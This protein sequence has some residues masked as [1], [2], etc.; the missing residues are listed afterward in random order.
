M[1]KDLPPAPPEVEET[2]VGCPGGAGQRR[3]SGSSACRRRH[4]E[5]R[6]APFIPPRVQRPARRAHPRTQAGLQQQRPGHPSRPS[7][8]SRPGRP[9]RPGGGPPAR[10]GSDRN[11]PPVRTFGPDAE[12]GGGRK[13]GQER[14]ALVGGSGSGA[15]QHHAYAPGDEGSGGRKGRRTDEPS[16]QAVQ[17]GRLAEEKEREK[18]LVR[19]N[20][21]VS[22][23]E[24]A[25]G[26]EGAGHPDRPV[27]VQGAGPD[28]DG[29]PAARLRSDRADRVRLWFPGGPGGR[30]R[31]RSGAG[32][33]RGESGRAG[34]ASAGRD[35][36]GSRGP[37]QDLAARLCPQG[38]HRGRRG[39]WHHPAHRRLSRRAAGRQADHLPRYAGPPGLHRHAGARRPGHRH[40]RARRGG[41]RPGHAAD[42]RGD[43]PRPQRRRADDRRHQ[44]DRSARP[45]TCRR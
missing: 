2:E 35:H 32:S 8:P 42:R 43:Q 27:R 40:R 24:L 34:L 14:Q 41:G 1:F 12:K 21:F 36:H 39:G 17:A 3:R 20:E 16:F 37:R 9:S 13:K 6:R 38:Q 4:A 10:P 7:S 25:G 26:H 22:V 11:A 33:G 44:Q 28:G 45:P 5:R 30:V 19:V 31:R 29:E 15:G 23:S 18:T